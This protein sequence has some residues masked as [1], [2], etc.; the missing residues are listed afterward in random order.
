MDLW[1]E[2]A[3]QLLYDVLIDQM[4]QNQQ[5]ENKWYIEGKLNLAL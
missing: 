1:L 4:K 2:K 3:N 5:R